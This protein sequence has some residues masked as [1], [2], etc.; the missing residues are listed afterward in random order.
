MR[1]LFFFFFFNDNFYLLPSP[2]MF[3]LENEYH[4]P[5][6]K[7]IKKFSH[8]AP[9][10]MFVVCL[11][12]NYREM[13]LPNFA[14]AYRCK[15][16]QNMEFS[17][18]EGGHQWPQIAKWITRFLAPPCMLEFLV[19][20]RF[21]QTQHHGPNLLKCEISAFQGYPQSHVGSYFHYLWI[22]M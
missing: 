11:I 17:R 12:T 22:H 3:K 5:P 9:T 16:S 14:C 7:K 18:D 21:P 1:T 15:D 6:Q 13:F 4:S 2:I 10:L 19:F 20:S 8:V